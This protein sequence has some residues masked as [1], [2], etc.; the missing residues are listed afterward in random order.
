MIKCLF[1]ILFCSFILLVFSQNKKDAQGRK[2]G[3]WQ[4]YAPDGITLI[5]SGQF[6]DDKPIGAFTYY[7]PSGKVK[8][9]IH[10]RGTG[11]SYAWFYFENEELMSEGKYIGTQKDSLWKNYNIEGF[12]LSTEWF[13]ENKLHGEK[14]SFYLQDQREYGALKIYTLETY[15][16]SLLQGPFATYLSSGIKVEEGNYVAGQK[17]GVWKRFYPNGQLQSSIKYNLGSAYGYSISYDEEGAVRSKSYWLN[18]VKLNNDELQKYLENCKKT[19][20]IPKE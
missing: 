7:Y 11:Q 15:A 4:K 13:K 2:Q 1:S 14:K 6:K 10:H 5:Y 17:D 3:P 18:G 20:E 8:T 9:M 19:G 12:L 16:D